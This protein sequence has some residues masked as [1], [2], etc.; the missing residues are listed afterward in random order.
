[1]TRPE[2]FSF[3][4]SLG[5]HF[6]LFGL[7]VSEQP[8]VLPIGE[9]RQPPVSV[10]LVAERVPAVESLPVEPEPE[11]PPVPDK[12]E[13]PKPE[14]EPKPKPKL[15]V[16]KRIAPVHTS[17]EPIAATESDSTPPPA[18]IPSIPA[19]ADVFSVYNPKPPYPTAARRLRHE[20]NVTVK[21]LVSKNGDPSSVL[22]EKSSGFRELDE[23]AVATV[24]RWRFRPGTKAGI[25]VDSEIVIP[26][27]FRLVD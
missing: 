25:P 4:L 6:G 24:K 26:I 14:P 12:D 11:P 27:R 17:S 13:M 16:A 23:S 21:V 19:S 5:V 18:D 3:L 1:V 10:E 20:G 15:T 7:P 8:M 9:T 2:L 22:L